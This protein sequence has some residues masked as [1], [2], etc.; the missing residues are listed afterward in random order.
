V[1]V[2]VGVIVLALATGLFAKARLRA[3]SSQ[4]GMLVD[5]GGY[6]LH[7]LC[8][9]QGGPAVLLEAGLGEFSLM[10]SLV[11][12]LV[13]RET[14]VCAYDRSGYGWSDLG[15]NPH[16]AE[17]A[18]ADLDAILR[19]TGIEGPYVLVG[20]SYGGLLVRLFANAYPEA[21]AGMVL[22]EASHEDMDVRGPE[23]YREFAGR[24]RA[25]W[26]SQLDKQRP[27]A[28]FGLTALA[29]G[30]VSV[31]PALPSVKQEAYR[32]IKAVDGKLF[33]AVADE[34]ALLPGNLSY[35]RGAGMK[36][37]GGIPVVVLTRG[38]ATEAA[39]EMGLDEAAAGA[40]TAFWRDDLQ[41]GLARLSSNGRHE[42]V[43]NSGHEMHYDDPQAIADAILEVVRAARQ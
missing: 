19:G 15:P 36:G 42:V 18:V 29:P 30:N 28:T 14:R 5:V 25:D 6:D 31:P 1:Y 35:A 27:L 32:L 26:V 9:G 17:A 16:S 24:Q 10:W 4:P 22:V 34:V 23:A 41:A 33:A 3:L 7:I 20:Q 43:T 39:P 40:W 13:A 12:P 21:V 2:L 37:L 11:Q 8:M 38:T